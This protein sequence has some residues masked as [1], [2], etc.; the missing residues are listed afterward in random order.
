MELTM[1]C[2]WD[3]GWNAEIWKLTM[4]C[5]WDVKWNETMESTKA[6]RMG[7]CFTLYTSFSFHFGISLLG[8]NTAISMLQIQR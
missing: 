6:C 5:E 7:Y 4:K 1:E 2:E 3:A 8:L